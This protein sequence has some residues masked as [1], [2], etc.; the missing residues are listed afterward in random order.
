M[1]KSPVSLLYE[2]AGRK[3]MDGISRFCHNA[4]DL[5]RQ[6]TII[7][8]G[9]DLFPEEIIR[10]SENYT[11]KKQAYLILVLAHN[12]LIGNMIYQTSSIRTT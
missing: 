5:I 8:S 3:R 2:L 11:S 10:I 9:D 1:V 6:D 7:R 12:I 4:G